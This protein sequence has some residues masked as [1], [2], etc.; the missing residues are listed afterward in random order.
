VPPGS[1]GAAFGVALSYGSGTEA[2]TRP[3]W[4][5]KGR[6]LRDN[7]RRLNEVRPW[8]LTCHACGHQAAV[9]TTLKRLRA[10][11][12]VCSEC[13][14]VLERRKRSFPP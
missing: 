4:K 13:G 1:I 6:Q 9:T 8:W 11:T 10:A 7:V 2:M 12:L 14:V 3:N 5:S